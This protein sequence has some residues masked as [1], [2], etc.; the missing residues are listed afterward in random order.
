MT[1]PPADIDVDLELARRL[2]TGQHPE[3]DGALQLETTGW[4]NV[5]F[6]LGH[7]LALRI[8]RRKI[9]ARLI[10]HE[11]RWLPKIAPHLPISIPAPVR[12]G[13]PANEFPYPWSVVPWVAGEIALHTPLVSTEGARL[14]SFLRALHDIPI[15]PDPPTNPYRGVPL[16]DRRATFDQRLAAAR[17]SLGDELADSARRLL[18]SA[19]SIQVTDGPSWI[20]GDLH[21]KNV[22]TKNGRIVS[23]IDWGDIC[24]GDPA[25]DLASLW[26][27]FD[28]ADHHH[29]WDTY[30]VIDEDLYTRSLGWAVAFGLMLHDSH[31]QADPAFAAAGVETIRR[32][33]STWSR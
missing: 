6:R 27:L 3:L 16:V 22:I 4:D 33:V 29:F 31:H 12:N 8:P 11:Q 10:D 9:A 21:S 17:R 15:A 20:H 18:R 14:G 19:M 5:I 26:I 1:P 23:V 32:A 7:D 25:T 30:G 24:T 13:L 2:L 28:P